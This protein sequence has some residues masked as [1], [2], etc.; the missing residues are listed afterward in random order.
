[1]TKNHTHLSNK[2]VCLPKKRIRSRFFTLFF[3]TIFIL[4]ALTLRFIP[5]KNSKQESSKNPIP[6]VLSP[7]SSDRP[8]IRP[9]PSGKQTYYL[10][11]GKK[12]IGPK[13]TEVTVDP[14]D[15][16]VGQKQTF[17]VKIKHSYQILQVRLTLETDHGKKSYTLSLIEGTDK[18]GV[19]Q[20]SWETGDTHDQN[21]YAFFELVSVK[22]T[23]QG[24]LTFR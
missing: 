17:T 8:A 9:L 14:L 4:S 23:Y 18:D 1:M 13:M 11:H 6:A 22:D 12:V 16:E 2:R 7:I 5:A 15:P 24:G 10:S 21:Y 3:L 19:W 20:G